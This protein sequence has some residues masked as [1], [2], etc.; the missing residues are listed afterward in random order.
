MSSAGREDGELLPTYDRLPVEFDRG[1]GV[2]LH[3]REGNRYLDA[4]AGIAV[5]VLGY[6]HPVL[7]EAGREALDGIHHLSNLF[8]IPPQ[9]ELARR[10]SEL[11]GGR[12]AFFCNSGAEAVEG[13][14]KFA[15]K[16]S[17][18][19]GNDGRTILS[20]ENSFHGRTLGALTATGQTKYQEGFGPL[21]D[22]FDQVPYNDLEALEDRMDD[23]VCAILLE[24]IQ[25]E[26][27]VIPAQE[28]YL[29]G[30]RNLCD[31]YGALMVVDEIQSGVGRTGEFLAVET[32]DVR[33]D[34]VALAKG[35]AGGFP[36]GALLVADSLEAGLQSGDHA[37]TFGGNPFVTTMALTVLDV[38]EDEGL[39]ESSRERGKQLERGLSELAGSVDGVGEPRGKGLMQGLPLGSSLDAS[40][41]MNEALD[42]GLLVG[43]AGENTLRFVPPLILTEPQVEDLLNRLET[44]VRRA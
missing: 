25:G 31:E 33:P 23:S 9:R 19:H 11:T 36:I 27:G 29:R 17:Y 42:E 26:G 34:V 21:P 4:L 30:V 6:R 10:L 2:Y 16:Y 38:L 40:D 8:E 22:G 28:E 15:R 3:D 44:V 20:A 14:I 12:R 32:Y 37:S 1:E 5:N 43:T 41:V 18:R 24:P 35:L 39:V 13:A 7:L